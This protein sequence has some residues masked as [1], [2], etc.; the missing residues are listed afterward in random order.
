MADPKK[1]FLSLYGP[2]GNTWAAR[3]TGAALEQTKGMISGDKGAASEGYVEVGG[4]RV[5]VKNLMNTYGSVE[6]E[7]KNKLKE[8]LRAELELRGQDPK[9]LLKMQIGD[10]VAL[11]K[12]LKETP[13]PKPKAPRL[14]PPTR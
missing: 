8:E 1:T 11:K 9:I 3:M 10:M 6:L 2:T 13:M 7:Y 4:V 5:S 14:E 12:E